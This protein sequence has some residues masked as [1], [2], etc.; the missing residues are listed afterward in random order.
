MKPKKYEEVNYI[1]IKNNLMKHFKILSAISIIMALIAAFIC[2]YC[3]KLAIE[4]DN[5]KIE[6]E[7]LRQVIE[8]QKYKED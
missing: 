8:M 7:E 5:L 6:N 2:L 4:V 1:A 3:M